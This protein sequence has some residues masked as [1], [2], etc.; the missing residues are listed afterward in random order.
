MM[1][2]AALFPQVLRIYFYFK[3]GKV[4]TALRNFTALRGTAG[5]YQLL[6]TL[7]VTEIKEIIRKE[8]LIISN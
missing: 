1:K 3:T 5:N 2:M 8:N 4:F 7:P 6:I